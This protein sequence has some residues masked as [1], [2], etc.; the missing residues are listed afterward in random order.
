MQLKEYYKEYGRKMPEERENGIPLSKERIQKILPFFEEPMLDVGCSKGY[1]V[2]YFYNKGF[3]K[4][5]GCDISEEVISVA[6]SFL[7]GHFFVHNFEEKKIKKK[8]K[9]IYSFDVIEHLFFTNEFLENIFYSILPK[10][11]LIIT[12]PNVLSIRNRINFLFGK[13]EYFIPKH[14]C[15]HIRFFN[16]KSLEQKLKQTGFRKVLFFNASKIP[17]MPDS[18]VGSITAVA[19]K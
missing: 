12:C 3:K 7:P 14:N 11:K 13:G 15:P 16:T 10:G 5:F 18:L 8:F 2:R 19:L 1:D 17:L 6:N 9:T 4:T